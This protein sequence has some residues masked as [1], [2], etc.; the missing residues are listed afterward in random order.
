MHL[1]ESR[2]DSSVRGKKTSEGKGVAGM[3]QRKIR[4]SVEACAL[5][6][7]KNAVHLRRWKRGELG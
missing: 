2:K 1:P 7:Q 3:K 6:N 5:T 4:F